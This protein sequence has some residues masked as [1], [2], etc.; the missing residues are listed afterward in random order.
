MTCSAIPHPAHE[1]WGTGT[2][3]LHP[4]AYRAIGE[5]HHD[6]HQQGD[7]PGGRVR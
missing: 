7:T 3:V 6:I 2:D 1:G 4:R 5:A